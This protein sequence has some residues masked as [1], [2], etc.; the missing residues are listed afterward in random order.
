MIK[1]LLV[2]VASLFLFV[3]IALA[4][5]EDPCLPEGFEDF[6]TEAVVIADMPGTCF[7]G[8]P[9]AIRHTMYKGKRVNIA[10]E[11]ETGR[12]LVLDPVPDDVNVKYFVR[13]EDE[14]CQFREILSHKATQ[15]EI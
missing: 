7:N 6:Y 12:L 4:E 10:S 3:G 8:I 1:K 2:G 9:C 5:H 13:V 11:L 15:K 14:K